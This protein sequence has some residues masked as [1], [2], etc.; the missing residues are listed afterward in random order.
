MLGSNIPGMTVFRPPRPKG[1]HARKWKKARVYSG[2]TLPGPNA[3]C[4]VSTTHGVQKMP[5]NRAL[6]PPKGVGG[7]P[8][9]AAQ[10]EDAREPQA[11]VEAA[12]AV[13]G[14]CL[15]RHWSPTPEPPKGKDSPE[16]GSRHRPAWWRLCE[17]IRGGPN[18]QAGTLWASSCPGPRNEVEGTR[19]SQ[20][21]G[22]GRVTG[23]TVPHE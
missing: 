3:S 12:A 15:G 11:M 6:Q 10:A 13:G 7:R 19:V 9:G 22:S 16:C 14:P 21:R 20:Q 18:G 2:P 8:Q 17:H 23:K 5:V 1:P 4:T